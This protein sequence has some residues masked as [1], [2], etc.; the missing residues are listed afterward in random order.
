MGCTA[1]LYNFICI[2]GGVECRQ[3]GY[4]FAEQGFS[5]TFEPNGDVIG[6]MYDDE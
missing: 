2:G 5:D 4:T 3:Q 6:L 1:Y